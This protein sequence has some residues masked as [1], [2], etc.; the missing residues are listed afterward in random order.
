MTTTERSLDRSRE[1]ID[2]YLEQGLTNIFL[3]PLSPYGFAIKTKSHAAYDVDRWLAFYEEGL[4]YIL[5]L[6][7]QGHR[8]SPSSTPRSS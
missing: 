6:N 3:R 5:E 1:I 4:D 7:T 2:C 8:R